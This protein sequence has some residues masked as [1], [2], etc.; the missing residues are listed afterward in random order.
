M[1]ELDKQIADE[2]EKQADGRKR[3]AEL[4]LFDQMFT[5]KIAKLMKLKAQ[6]DKIYSQANEMKV[7]ELA[8]DV[9]LEITSKLK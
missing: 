7:G 1:T 5:K 3:M 2:M 4:K 8:S 6:E 9:L